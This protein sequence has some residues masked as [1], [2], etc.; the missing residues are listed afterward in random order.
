MKALIL[1]AG[2]GKRL[3]P[4]TNSIPKSMVEGMGT[5]LLVNALNNLV[6]CGIQEIGIV[7]GH[8]ADYIKEK[9]GNSFCGASISYYENPRYLE[10]NNVVSLYEAMDFCDDDMLMLE[11]DLF[12]HKEML[13][14]LLAGN[15]E[16]SILVSPFDAE[17]MDGTVIEVDGDHAR[18]LVLGKWQGPDYDYA[19]ARKTVNLYKFEKA[20]ISQK[21]MPLIKWYVENMGENSYYEKILG[22]LIYYRECDVRVV[23]VPA[24][25]WCEIDDMADLE[26]ARTIFGE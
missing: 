20:F 23:E 9:I 5:P 26:R 8:M 10:T 14:R 24:S 6:D 25:M 1:A 7:V 13:E 17:T 3:Q 2:Y 4:I 22:S 19:K 15:G 18:A 12:Y 16:C 21:Y 11:C